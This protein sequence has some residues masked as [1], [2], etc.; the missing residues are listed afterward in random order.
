MK[1]STKTELINRL[2]RSLSTDVINEMIADI[3]KNS[4]QDFL[5]VLERA[6]EGRKSFMKRN[7]IQNYLAGGIQLKRVEA[8]RKFKVTPVR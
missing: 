2:H 7:M 3:R 4:G 6:L 8:G 5:Y 1:N